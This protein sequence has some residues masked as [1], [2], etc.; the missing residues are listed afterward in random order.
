M[1]LFNKKQ[2]KTVKSVY[3]TFTAGLEEV[4]QEQQC[5]ANDAAD[6]VGRLQAKLN[7]QSTIQNLAMDE[8]NQATR[9]IKNIAEMLGIKTK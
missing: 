4:I 7:A 8:V 6:E 3:S 2:A 9:G 1:S 5:A